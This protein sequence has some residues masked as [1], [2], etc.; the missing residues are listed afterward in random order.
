[1]QNSYILTFDN[2]YKITI[3]CSFISNINFLR[4]IQNIQINYI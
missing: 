4:N 1:M 3:T 2:S